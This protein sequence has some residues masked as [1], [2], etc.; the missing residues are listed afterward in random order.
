MWVYNRSEYCGIVPIWGVPVPLILPICEAFDHITFENDKAVHIHF[1]KIQHPGIFFSVNLAGGDSIK[2]CPGDPA[3]SQK[4][5]EILPFAGAVSIPHTEACRRVAYGEG[6]I[7]WSDGMVNSKIDPLSHKV[8]GSIPV[9]ESKYVT[10]ER[11]SRGFGAI[12][13]YSILDKKPVLSRI[14]PASGQT[15]NTI[16]LGSEALDVAIGSDSVWVLH[17]QQLSRID[18]KNNQVVATIPL[19]SYF[20]KPFRARIACG[21][22]SVWVASG[23]TVV[24]IDP[25]ENRIDSNFFVDLDGGSYEVLEIASTENALWIMAIKSKGFFDVYKVT[26]VIA[27][28]DAKTNTLRSTKYLGS[29]DALA[30]VSSASLALA[31]DEVWV[32]LP[33]GIYVIP[34]NAAQ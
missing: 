2:R 31:E 5:A 17:A 22:R 24:R 26:V 6:V 32:C 14:D 29:D 8:L 33:R 9:S 30:V 10:L 7:W 21:G 15:I 28:F 23:K 27:E 13:S 16:P 1:R 19:E 4:A 25:E 12:W 34:K 20:A 11:T 18:P 3:L